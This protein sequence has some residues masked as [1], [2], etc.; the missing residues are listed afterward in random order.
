MLPSHYM[1]NFHGYEGLIGPDKTLNAADLFLVTS[2]LF[3][4]GSSS[5]PGNTPEP[6]HGGRF[7]VITNRDNVEAVHRLPTGDLKITISGPSLGFSMGPKRP[8]SG[9]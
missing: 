3:G 5:S 6:L 9:R 1:A 4:T 2:E 8:F 7:P